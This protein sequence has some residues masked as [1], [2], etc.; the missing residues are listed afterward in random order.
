MLFQVT[1]CGKKV[2]PT[3]EPSPE[4]TPWLFPEPQIKLLESDD[5][6]VRG[7]AIKNLEKMG[8]KAEIAIP[9][10]EK[11]LDDKEPN[12]RSLAEEAIKKI[13]EA[14]GNSSP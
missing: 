13:R 12:I 6:R 9:A 5:M 8:A 4:E 1:G 10:L 3:V 7:L 14:S 2:V 11:L